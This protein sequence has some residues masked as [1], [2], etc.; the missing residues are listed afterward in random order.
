MLDSKELKLIFNHLET[1]SINPIHIKINESTLNIPNTNMF[2][3]NKTKNNIVK[4][5]NHCKVIFF[6]FDQ[7]IC[8]WNFRFGI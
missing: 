7:S 1:I 8:F 2:L 4:L 6:M 3:N 5:T